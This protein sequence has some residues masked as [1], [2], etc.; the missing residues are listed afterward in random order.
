MIAFKGVSIS[1]K[2][3]LFS[4]ETTGSVFWNA[5]LVST[6]DH[7]GTSP[8]ESCIDIPTAIEPMD[9]EIC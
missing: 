5:D 3:F 9:K 8:R 2:S 1:T 6:V 7:A 4:E